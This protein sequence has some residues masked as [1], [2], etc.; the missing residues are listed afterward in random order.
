MEAREIKTDMT[1]GMRQPRAQ[2]GDISGCADAVS[3]L[4]DD[5]LRERRYLLEPLLERYMTW[6]WKN[7]S[8]RLRSSNAYTHD[9]LTFGV[10]WRCYGRRAVAL[11][12]PF[13]WLMS[14]LTLLR[15]RFPRTRPMADRLRG[16]LAFPLLGPRFGD[17]D[18]TGIP[19]RCETRALLGW[20]HAT[21]EFERELPR[22]CQFR[23]FLDRCDRYEREWYLAQL[24]AF[25]AR[26]GMLAA[27][28]APALHASDTT[29]D[30][31]IADSSPPGTAKPGA[32]THT[33]I[34]HVLA[35]IGRELQRRA[36]SP[37]AGL[38]AD[39]PAEANLI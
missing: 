38:C 32:V 25:T 12:P 16:W 19:S 4:T 2:V 22:L 15:D 8:E 1:E 5:V 37:P 3:E 39:A 30:T 33:R 31:V 14:G 20:M 17:E 29:A 28:R 35:V 9:V 21:G 11:P 13:A 6:I 18:A 34:E 24:S 26:F 27:H 36:A 23:A 10:M 7:G